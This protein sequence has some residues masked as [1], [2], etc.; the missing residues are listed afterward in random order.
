[1]RL[2][3]PRITVVL[4]AI[5]L[6]LVILLPIG[7]SAQGTLSGVYKVDGKAAALTQVAAYAGEPES[8]QPTTV[9]VFTTKAP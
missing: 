5:V 6:S 7:A 2:I 3:L 1:M 4:T 9:L 8:G